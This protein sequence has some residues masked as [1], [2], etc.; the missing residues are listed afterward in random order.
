MKESFLR[1]LILSASYG[2]GHNQVARAVTEAIEENESSVEAQTVD[3]FEFVSQPVNR[4]VQLLYVQSVRHLP[5]GYGLFYKTT[6]HI[7]P[8][9]WWQRQLNNMGHAQLK[10]HLDEANPD[11]II[12]TFPTPAGVLSE[13]RADG[14]VRVP[15]FAIVTDH[16]IHSQWIHPHIDHYFVADDEVAEGLSHRGIAEKRI[17]VSGIPIIGAFNNLPDHQEARAKLQLQPDLP[18]VLVMA[19]AFSMLGG[20][21]DILR[22]LSRL[23]VLHQAVIVAGTNQRL[24]SRLRRAAEPSRH[25]VRILGFTND[26]PTLMCASDLLITKAGGITVSEALA[27]GLPIVTYRLI[28]GQEEVNMR[29]LVKNGAGRFA[30]NPAELESV[31]SLLLSEDETR[32]KVGVIA[33]TLARP[34][35]AAVVAKKVIDI[36]EPTMMAEQEQRDILV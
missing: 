33:R 16:A 6:S 28:P 18:V 13:M 1:I 19:G 34:D 2:A 7:A 12:C 10:E 31:V 23:D 25:P 24:A 30:R 4:A 15:V 20:L 26:V 21:P 27:C 22:V 17:T 29:Y 5:S 35:A 14:R 32:K 9:S 8:D 11:A 36:S 3:F